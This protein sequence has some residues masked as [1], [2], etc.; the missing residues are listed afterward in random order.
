[1]RDEEATIGGHGE[2]EQA[3]NHQLEQRHSRN[4]LVRASS[5]PSDAGAVNA[6]DVYECAVS[7]I[8]IYLRVE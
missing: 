7:I 2:L 5:Q 1:M 6:S 3:A 4:P 8:R